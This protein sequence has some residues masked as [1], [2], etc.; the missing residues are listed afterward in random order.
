MKNIIIT[1]ER[2]GFEEVKDVFLQAGF[3]PI[4]FPLIRFEPVEIKNPNIIEEYE[5]LIFTSK[6]AVKYFFHQI[7]KIN[8]KII[9]VGE[10]TAEYLQ[11]LGYKDIIIPKTY[12]AEGVKEYIEENIKEFADKK[13]ALIRALEGMDT[14][15]NSNFKIDV[16]AV[17]KTQLNIPENVYEIKLLIEDGK[18]YAIVFS[19][20]STFKGFLNIFKEKSASLLKKMKV[21]AI[22]KTTKNFIENQ[23]FKVDIMPDKFTFEEIIKK[24]KVVD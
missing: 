17:Y 1:R 5:Y 16:I 20:P 21:V 8:K 24:L 14:L 12:S 10:K 4:C 2:S 13:I 15:L 22:G 19:S 7:P 9:A 3:N 11:K 23:G 18:I 6:N